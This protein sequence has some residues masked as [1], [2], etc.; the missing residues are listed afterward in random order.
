M[1]GQSAQA[2]CLARQRLLAARSL[3]GHNVQINRL[4]SSCPSTD[5]GLGNCAN[6]LELGCD[7]LGNIHYFDGVLNNSKCE[8]PLAAALPSADAADTEAPP[9][10]LPGNNWTFICQSFATSSLPAL[11]LPLLCWQGSLCC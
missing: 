6:S 10:V 11:P 9:C 4:L 2:G 1:S 3:M 5:Y 7:C 8:R